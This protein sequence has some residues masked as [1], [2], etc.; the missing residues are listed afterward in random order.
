MHLN[1][2][3][4]A[5]AGGA[6]HN[7]AIPQCSEAGLRDITS[8]VKENVALHKGQIGDRLGSVLERNRLTLWVF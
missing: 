5:A 2:R 1:N 6:A 4:A 3:R 8:S 7:G